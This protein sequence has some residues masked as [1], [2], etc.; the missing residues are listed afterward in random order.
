LAAGI[1]ARLTPKEGRKFGL[2]VGGAFLAIAA[3]MWWK[4]HQIP[5][6]VTAT[7]GTLLV[8]AGLVIPATL[9]PVFRGWMAFGLLLSKVTTPIFM[10]I[11]F[12]IVI[13]PLGLLRR[14]ISGNALIPKRTAETFWHSRPVNERRGNLQR[15]F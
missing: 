9:G 14:A 10:S 7:L 8:L 12:F 15:Q 3:L 5:M 13:T 11:V 1:P 2:T 4:D 6:Y